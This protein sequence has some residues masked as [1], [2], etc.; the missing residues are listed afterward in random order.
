MQHQNLKRT[1]CAS[2]CALALATLS[3]TGAEVAAAPGPVTIEGRLFYNDLRSVGHAEWRRTPDG[4][5]GA[6]VGYT[7]GAVNLLAAWYV[8]ADV[9]ELDSVD[10]SPAHPNC[11][12]ETLLG[13]STINFRGEYRFSEA[14]P[15][16]DCD[17]DGDTVPDL[18]VRFRLRFCND[19]RCFSLEDDDQLNYRLWHRE[20]RPDAPLAGTPGLHVLP[21]GTFQAAPHDDY[22]KAANLYAGVVEATD[23]LH[24]ENDLPFFHGGEEELFVRYPSSTATVPSTTSGH[25]IHYPATTWIAGGSHEIGHV[26]H[27]RA[28]DGTL[29]ACGNCPGGKYD[30]DGNPSWG[31]ITREYP[32]AAFMEG[33]ANFV[34]RVIDAWPD[35]CGD[36]FDDNDEALLCNADPSQYPQSPTP[37]TYP[38]DGKSYARNVTKLLCDWYD[39]GAWN[40]DDPNLAGGGDHFTA[41]LT[42][43]W[44]NLEA[45]WDYTGGAAGIEICDYIDY[46]LNDRKSV[47]SVGQAAHD[48]YVEWIT[49]LAYNNGISCFL[50]PPPLP[51]APPAMNAEG[52]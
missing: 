46:Y 41:T 20:A 49:D 29:G 34:S 27:S 19:T 1:A 14:V 33:W 5:V 6:L 15:A 50:A 3:F 31:A 32:H 11:A 21:D 42:S 52:E 36:R 38:N 45:L 2:A 12:S 35:G 26:V 18:G 23:V 4:D 48:N 9:I 47:A 24:L 37:I 30:R 22:A 8:V 39:D 13:S 10:T 40:D 28:W 51:L 43:I 44:S 17:A 25:Q 7:P 16:D